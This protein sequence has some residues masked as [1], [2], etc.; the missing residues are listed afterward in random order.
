MKIL[1]NKFLNYNFK[2]NK[3]FTLIEL[4]VSMSIFILVLSVSLVNYRQGKNNDLFRLQAFD[5]E[6]SIRSTQ[7]MALTGKEIEHTIP[8]AYGIFL[9]AIHKDIIIY[10]DQD[11]NHVFDDSI[12]L[13]YSHN[14]LHDNIDFKLHTLFCN[15]TLIAPSL[16]I[17]FIPPQPKVMINNLPTCTSTMISITSE[18]ANGSW[19]IH[20][21]SITGRTWT[22]FKE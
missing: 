10:G 14:V 21:D 17:D 20:F 5:I 3:A 18:R 1:K 19:N 13:I 15:S 16:D 12:D 22:E 4:L 11:A 6:D 7:N 8:V 9:D 2:V